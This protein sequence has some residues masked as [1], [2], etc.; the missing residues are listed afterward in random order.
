MR[1]AAV[2]ILP[3]LAPLLL[4]V[5]ASVC[6]A[7]ERHRPSTR[8]AR[9]AQRAAAATAAASV[10]RP[11]DEAPVP[12]LPQDAGWVRTVL[13]VLGVIVVAGAVIGPVY[14]MWAP[15]EMLPAHAH[16][17]PPGASHRHGPGGERVVGK[18]EG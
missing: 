8:A 15:E 9:A 2:G 10:A 7:Q 18:D 1:L 11:G 5:L 16:D 13:V 17:E 14:R 4:L 12:V 6:P 3:P